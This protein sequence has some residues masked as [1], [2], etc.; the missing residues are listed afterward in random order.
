M[1]RKPVFV[2]DVIA[3]PGSNAGSTFHTGVRLLFGRAG[4]SSEQSTARTTAPTARWTTGR[5]CR[6]ADHIGGAD[7]A[8]LAVVHE[9][10]QR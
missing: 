1:W 9:G 3:D 5:S 2:V 7:A 8:Q 4:V 10:P 6:S